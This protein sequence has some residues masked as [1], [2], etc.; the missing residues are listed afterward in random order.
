[1]EIEVQLPDPTR[2]NEANELIRERD[3]YHAKMQE[4][5]ARIKTLEFDMAELQKRDVQLTERLKEVANKSNAGYRPRR[6]H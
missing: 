4:A 5:Q 2:S 6:R 1:M 3:F